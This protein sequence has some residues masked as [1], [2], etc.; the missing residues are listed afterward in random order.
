MGE[1]TSASGVVYHV[2]LMIR[3]LTARL[4]GLTYVSVFVQ[5]WY[6]VEIRIK[7]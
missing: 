4:H 7:L 6:Q 3:L 5:V 1:R 2:D